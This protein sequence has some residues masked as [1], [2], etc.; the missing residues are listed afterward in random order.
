[1]CAPWETGPRRRVRGR[2]VG[3]TGHVSEGIG[4]Y[5][6]VGLRS[7]VGGTYPRNWIMAESTTILAGVRWFIL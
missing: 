7:S 6:A 2:F 3:R 1:M 5:S 4:H